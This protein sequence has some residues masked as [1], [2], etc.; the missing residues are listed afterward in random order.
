M[1]QLHH[2]TVGSPCA[3]CSVTVARSR[4]CSDAA[5]Q[6]CSA[7][8]VVRVS[9]RACSLLPNSGSVL[10][11]AHELLVVV[12]SLTSPQPSMIVVV[13]VL[14]RGLAS[15]SGFVGCAPRVRG[16]VVATLGSRVRRRR[17]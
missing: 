6:V 13:S 17:G 2:P 3:H 7:W 16:V 12:S 11:V 4:V 15:R 10:V 5:E 9:A 1:G 14:L 8:V